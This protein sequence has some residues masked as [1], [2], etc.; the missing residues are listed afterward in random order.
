MKEIFKSCVCVCVCRH[1]IYSGRQA[2]GR[3]VEII[4]ILIENCPIIIFV[5]VWLRVARVC[6][7]INTHDALEGIP[8]CHLLSS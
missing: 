3:T 7:E 8:K 4:E 2:C 1:P 5:D 6:R